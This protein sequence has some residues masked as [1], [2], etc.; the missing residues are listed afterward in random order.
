[1]DELDVLRR[2]VE[3]PTLV[4]GRSTGTRVRRSCTDGYYG[5]A[6]CGSQYIG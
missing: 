2:Q 4:T 5:R 3:R 1:V 6:A